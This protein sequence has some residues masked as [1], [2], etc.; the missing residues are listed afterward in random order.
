MKYKLSLFLLV[1]SAGLFAQISKNNVG[2]N[3]LDEL[4]SH[5]KQLTHFGQR[6]DWFHDGSK[7]LFIEKTYGDVYEYELESGLIKRD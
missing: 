4:P 2:K 1:V 7:F 6:A 3:P 5:I